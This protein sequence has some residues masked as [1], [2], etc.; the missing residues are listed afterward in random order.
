MP[1]PSGCYAT[2]L[3]GVSVSP[4][5]YALVYAR[6]GNYGLAFGLAAVLLATSPR[7]PVSR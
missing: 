4:I 2:F 3:L 6:N 5:G 7:F 1:G